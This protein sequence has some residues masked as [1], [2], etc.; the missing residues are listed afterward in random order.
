MGREWGRGRE[1]HAADQPLVPAGYA[2]GCPWRLAHCPDRL[3]AGGGGG[4]RGP[5]DDCLDHHVSAHR[6]AAVS[7]HYW[8]DRGADGDVRRG[9]D[10]LAPLVHRVPRPSRPWERDRGSHLRHLSPRLP[11]PERFRLERARGSCRGMTLSFRHQAQRKRRYQ[12]LDE[13]FVGL[14]VGQAAEELAVHGSLLAGSEHEG[15]GSLHAG[16][17]PDTT[18]PLLKP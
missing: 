15:R 6:L 3:A 18:E 16:A 13:A 17:G 2:R 5:S 12:I 7:L 4:W 8:V 1:Q 14:G 9:A 10:H 11:G